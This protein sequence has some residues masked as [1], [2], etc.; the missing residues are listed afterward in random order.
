MEELYIIS[1]GQRHRLDLDTPSG[2]VLSFESNLFGDLSKITSSHSYTFRLPFTQNNRRVLDAADDIRSASTVIGR[3]MKCEYLYNGM[4]II[5][6]GNIY[7]D[8]VSDGYNAV[9][10]FN[11]VP[12]FKELNDDGKSIRELVGE[13]GANDA[14]TLFD[15]EELENSFSNTSANVWPLYYAGIKVGPKWSDRTHITG[16]VVHRYRGYPCIPIYAILA[17]IND[18][19][20]TKFNLGSER[21]YPSGSSAITGDIM[22]RGVIPFVRGVLNEEDAT[23]FTYKVGKGHG[24]R[25]LPVQSPLIGVTEFK[26]GYD[27]DQR[28]TIELVATSISPSTPITEQGTVNR[29]FTDFIFIMSELQTDQ[30]GV[31]HLRVSGNIALEFSRTAIASMDSSKLAIEIWGECES[32]YEHTEDASELIANRILLASIGADAEG[33]SVSNILWGDD[34]LEG[35]VEID[36]DLREYVRE[37]EARPGGIVPHPS[38]YR[39]FT[40]IKNETGYSPDSVG[41]PDGKT[42]IAIE[43]VASYSGGRKDFFTHPMASLPDISCMDFVKTLYQLCGGVPYVASDGSVKCLRYDDIKDNMT[44]GQYSDWSSKVIGAIQEQP[45]VIEF[46]I[47]GICRNNHLKAKSDEENGNDVIYERG[48]INVEVGGELLE[49]SA[50][51]MTIPFYT[52]VVQDNKAKVIYNEPTELVFRYPERSGFFST[53]RSYRSEGNYDMEDEAKAVIGLLKRV[54]LANGTY[55]IGM[56]IMNGFADDGIAEQYEYLSQILAA[57]RVIEETL[58]LDEFDVM[59]IDYTKPVYIEKYNSFFAIIGIDFDTAG[60]SKC[61]LLRLPN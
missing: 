39:I 35:A 54:S 18:E 40:T 30:N 9:M 20:G 33:C 27:Y 47:D 7:I 61:R 50:D 45:D 13:D 22:D 59:D 6:D 38:T 42:P 10:T 5:H 46:G 8:N 37:G 34:C 11:V 12:G 58:R 56:D 19:Y 57:P 52:G 16:S 21:S 23:E 44:N 31:I 28:T 55:A 26:L 32:G 53:M 1:D 49:E 15:K 60:W 2:I 14:L 41:C 43:V 51:V 4:A 17:M 24:V 36:I 48:G 29:W 3:M 25:L